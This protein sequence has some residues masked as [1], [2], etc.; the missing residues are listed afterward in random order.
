VR[1]VLTGS[2]GYSDRR[3]W[4]SIPDATWARFLGVSLYALALAWIYWSFLTLGK[5][6]SA[7]VTIQEGHQLITRGLRT[8]GC[9]IP[10]T[11]D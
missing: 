8:D 6:H 2:S 3:S 7:E 9:A 10:C 4:P 11:W 5:Q 1:R